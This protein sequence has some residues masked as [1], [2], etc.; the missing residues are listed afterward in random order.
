M[1]ARA[2]AS[3]VHD[4][5]AWF[6]VSV[7][8]SSAMLVR[9][10]STYNINLRC[11]FVP[12]SVSLSLCSRSC[13]LVGGSRGC[14]MGVCNSAATTTPVLANVT[15]EM[16]KR[17]VTN[18][19]ISLLKEQQ[20]RMFQRNAKMLS[21][22]SLARKASHAST[23]RNNGISNNMAH[24][25]ASGKAIKSF[26]S[27]VLCT[28]RCSHPDNAVY[29]VPAP[30]IPLRFLYFATALLLP[31]LLLPLWTWQN[32]RWGKQKEGETNNQ[33]KQQNRRR[34]NADWFIF[35]P[36]LFGSSTHF[37]FVYQPDAPNASDIHEKWAFAFNQFE[38]ISA[39]CNSR[40][41]DE[42]ASHRLCLYTFP[43]RDASI[44]EIKSEFSIQINNNFQL[45]LSMVR[46]V[47]R[48]F[49]NV[50]IWM[51]EWNS[52]T[53]SK[54]LFNLNYELHFINE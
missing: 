30:I 6:N 20:Q 27:S 11:V 49:S 2:S 48:H 31:F 28:L 44:C 3:T 21:E 45:N 23:N 24:G 18:Q 29:P 38:F 41:R 36:F 8:V 39:A 1:Y 10:A 40:S 5:S 19:I 51:S 54:V 35:S 16:R 17:K 26:K 4:D 47:N 50:R 15:T 33:R 37:S 7:S 32:Q 25:Q 13:V 34:K 53:S 14:S 46:S 9:I 12:I 43:F 52:L 22:L 42:R